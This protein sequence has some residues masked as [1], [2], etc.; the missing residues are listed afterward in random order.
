MYIYIYIYMY[1]Y[2]TKYHTYHINIILIYDIYIY[3]YDT[4]LSYYTNTVPK[5]FSNLF[6]YQNARFC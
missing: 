4:L 3:M 6:V 1:A 5:V 2:H